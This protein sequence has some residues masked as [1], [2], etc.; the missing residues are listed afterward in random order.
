VTGSAH[1]AIVPLPP[2]AAQV[3]TRLLAHT[4]LQFDFP[5]FVR[6]EPPEWLQAFLSALQPFL[7]VLKYAFWVAVTAGALLFVCLAAR[8]LWR[9]GWP[10]ERPDDNAAGAIPDWRP[11][12]DSARLLLHD[13]DAKAA[14]GHYGA[15]AHL[16][17]LRSIQDIDAQRPALLKPALTSREIGA[18]EQMPVAARTAFAF[19]AC[20]VERAL[21]AERAVGADEYIACRAQY[22]RFA[23]SDTWLPEGAP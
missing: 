22:A 23:F 7:P 10:R 14:E 20:V 5:R 2:G 9:D 1:S 12:P 19:I 8:A 21:F 11:A 4:D 6:P 15:A 3:H 18:L 17:L 16:L 13:A